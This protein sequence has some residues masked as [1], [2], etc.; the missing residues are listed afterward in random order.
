MSMMELVEYLHHD[1]AGDAA[2][3]LRH[4]PVFSQ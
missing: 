4:R 2:V 1:V 3:L